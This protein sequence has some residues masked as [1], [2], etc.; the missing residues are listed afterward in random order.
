MDVTDWFPKFIDGIVSI[1]LF[2][3]IN[4]P[5]IFWSGWDYFQATCSIILLIIVVYFVFRKL[6]SL[7]SGTRWG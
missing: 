6:L 7:G 4:K 5:Q 2:R 3:W 1:F